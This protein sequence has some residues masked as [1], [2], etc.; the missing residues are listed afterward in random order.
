MGYLLSEP[1]AEIERPSLCDGKIV[2]PRV[3]NVG[4]KT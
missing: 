2:S 4:N 3:H 1:Q